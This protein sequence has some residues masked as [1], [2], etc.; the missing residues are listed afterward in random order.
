M[1]AIATVST[2]DAGAGDIS[3]RISFAEAFSD[4]AMILFAASATLD[5]ECPLMHSGPPVCRGHSMSQFCVTNQQ[6]LQPD[7]S[8]LMFC[9]YPKNSTGVGPNRTTHASVNGVGEVN[10][11]PLGV[12]VA[13]T[14]L[15]EKRGLLERGLPI[16]AMCDAGYLLFLQDAELNDFNSFFLKKRHNLSPLLHGKILGRTVFSFPRSGGQQFRIEAVM[17][18]NVR[19]S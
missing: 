3:A 10:E 13:Q 11:T 7:G 4:S 5:G 12:D 1:R 2:K 18:G 19:F 9:G 6:A 15:D 17:D 16:E 14:V 8:K